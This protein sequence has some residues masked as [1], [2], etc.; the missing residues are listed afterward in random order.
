MI[1]WQI[2]DLIEITSN[3]NCDRGLFVSL[4]DY[5]DEAKATAENSA[6]PIKLITGRDI[7]ED[8]W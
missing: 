6:R 2:N 1:W 4:V 7:I 3:D 5:S 8:N